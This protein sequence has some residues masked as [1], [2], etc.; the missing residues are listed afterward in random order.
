[1][2]QLIPEE[3]PLTDE[4]I[5]EWRRLQRQL[6]LVNK[7]AQTAPTPWWRVFWNWLRRGKR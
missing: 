1:M 4:E 7:Y 5:A 2:N 3:R 6:S